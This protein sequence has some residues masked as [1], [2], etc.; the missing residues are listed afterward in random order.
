MIPSK[1]PYSIGMILD[2][3]REAL[4]GLVEGGAAGDGPRLEG[5]FELE[6]EVEV[7]VGR[8]V[9]V[10]DEEPPRLAR[11]PARGLAGAVGRAL[12]AIPFQRIGGEVV[13]GTSRLIA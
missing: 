1:S 6:P 8:G 3:H 13:S 9:L 5:A 11:D 4:V 7:H 12:G 10:H 2:V